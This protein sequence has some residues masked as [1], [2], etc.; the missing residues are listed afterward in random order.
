MPGRLTVARVRPAR[1][2]PTVDEEERAMLSPGDTAPDF[3]LTAHT[4]DVVDSREL[5]EE[6]RWL[7]VW[8][9]PK[10]ATPG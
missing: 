2:P 5:R 6:G 10:A 4:G 3:Q 7:A 9:Y 1:P 8:W